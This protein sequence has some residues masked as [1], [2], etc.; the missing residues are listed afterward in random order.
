MIPGERKIYQQ[1]RQSASLFRNSIKMNWH[2]RKVISWNLPSS[3]FCIGS[4][5]GLAIGRR[6][7]V[8]LE[9]LNSIKQRRL[10]EKREI[11]TRKTKCIHSHLKK[12]IFFRANPFPRYPL[13]FVFI[14]QIYFI[15]NHSQPYF[16]YYVSCLYIHLSTR[17]NA[18]DIFLGK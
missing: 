6:Y 4:T 18:Y 17:R 12:F 9:R 1:S 8:E 11:I 10:G 7:I 16:I 2:H 5:K 15:L 14:F 3:A 13:C